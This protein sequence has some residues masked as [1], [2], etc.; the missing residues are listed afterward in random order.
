MLAASPSIAYFFF[1]GMTLIATVGIY[2]W[3]IETKGASLE[4]IEDAYNSAEASSSEKKKRVTVTVS[5][6]E[7]PQSPDPSFVYG[8]R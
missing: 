2:F 4:A 3:M 1:G 7:E 6:L 5:A 8:R